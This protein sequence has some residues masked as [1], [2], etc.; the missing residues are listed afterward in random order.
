MPARRTLVRFV[1][2]GV[3]V[4][5]A[6]GLAL[7]GWGVSAFHGAGPSVRYITLV[8]P[9]GSSLEAIGHHLA[10]AGAIRDTTLFT[11]GVRVSGN[12]RKVRA[13]E[14][15]LAA[16][17]SLREIMNLLV[18]G[19]T[20]VRRVTLAEGLT[21]REIVAIL[22]ATEGLAGDIDAI[23]AEGSLLPDTYHFAYGDLRTDLIARLGRAMD[24]ALEAEWRGRQPELPFRDAAEARV[25]ASIVEKETALA[26]E[27]PRIAGVFINRLRRSMRL[28]SDPTVV[29][30]IT[31]GVGPLDRA[32]TR[33]DV[34]RPHPY[35]TYVISGLPP[36][37]IANPGRE[38]IIAVMNPMFTDEL[39]FV[40]DGTGGH[41]FA[42]NLDDHLK[43]VA[44]WRR[45][46]GN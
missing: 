41:A 1:L 22:N 16:A 39:Y 24:E 36:G 2:L 37:P 19:E 18:G 27:R 3:A 21:S 45:L 38:S 9:R 34:R 31:G 35:N 23:P 12:S 8:L 28:Q 44:R 29:Y 14:Y 15:R 42:R 26:H 30:G 13:G 32:L 11:L 10:T 46:R 7:F 17:A 20:V 6:A 40:A 5:V 33:A 25:L 4:A 43:N